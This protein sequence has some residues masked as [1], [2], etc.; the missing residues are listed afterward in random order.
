MRNWFNNLDDKYKLLLVGGLYVGTLLFASVELLCVACL[1]FAIVFTV[2]YVQYKKPNTDQET[3][4]PTNISNNPYHKPAQGIKKIEADVV[5]PKID[6]GYFLRWHYRESI[7]LPQNLDKIRLND[8][9]IKLVPEPDNQYDQN[10][11]ALYKGEYKLGYLYKGRT[12]EMVGS[13]IDRKD[14]QIKTVVCLLD[15]ENSKLAVR[16]AF[17][18]DLDAVQLETLTAPLT[19]ITKKSEDWG[20]SRYENVSMLYVGDCVDIVENDDGGYTVYDEYGNEL[21]ELSASTS[22]KIEAFDIIYAKIAN[23][24]LTE[25]DTYKVKVSIFYR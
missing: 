5:F 24:E 13:Y 8:C 12:Q 25:S 10:A 7:A 14:Y 21:G 17:Y 11:V 18:R 9:D 16:I 6:G 3:P 1:I 19:R 20:S 2:F 22:E 4:A 23:I 15:P